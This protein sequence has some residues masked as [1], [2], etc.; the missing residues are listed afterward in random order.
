MA[1]AGF[2]FRGSARYARV[3]PEVPLS[4]KMT[5]VQTATVKPPD[6]NI[7]WPAIALVTVIL[8]WVG[9]FFFGP[10]GIQ[11]GP[12]PATAALPS[13]ST[14]TIEKG[15]GAV[16]DVVAAHCHPSELADQGVLPDAF[17]RIPAAE[18]S[19]L[20]THGDDAVLSIRY[21]GAEVD[22]ALLT[23]LMSQM[24]G[25][26]EIERAERLDLPSWWTATTDWAP[27][28]PLPM[29]AEGTLL[30]S[31]TPSGDVSCHSGEVAGAMVFWDGDALIVHRWKET[32]DCLWKQLQRGGGGWKR[33]GFG[34]GGLGGR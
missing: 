11:D 20:R 22:D 23:S 34:G 24:S 10:R 6:R 27:V 17:L 19:M 15:L 30:T 5:G 4:E 25:D 3:H 16:P 29:G 32:R 2:L 9:W 7:P 14:C 26:S 12:W 28:W 31:Q 33:Q 13:T 8:L 18:V 1:R 21:D